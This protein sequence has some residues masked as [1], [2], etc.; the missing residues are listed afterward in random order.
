MKIF[1]FSLLTLLLLSGCKSLINQDFVY[2]EN[3]S[4]VDVRA[5]IDFLK[6]T[7]VKYHYD[8]N[9]ENRKAHIFSDLDQIG[10]INSSISLDSF[11]NRIAA[12]INSVDDGHSRIIHQSDINR[13]SNNFGINRI[14]N[15]VH[16]LRISNFLETHKLKEVLVNFKSSFEIKPTEKVLIDIRS[17]PGGSIENVKYFLSYFLPSKTELY[18]RLDIKSSNKLYNIISYFEEKKYNIKLAKTTG[19]KNLNGSPEIYLLINNEIASGSMLSSYHLQQNGA[20]IIGHPPNGLFNTF[21]NARGHKLPNSKIVYTTAT[22]RIFLSKQTPARME[23]M[24]Q[25]DYL[26]SEKMDINQII[27]FIRDR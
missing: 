15:S 11:E 1:Y 2:H 10:N 25:S 27:D 17:N 20:Y 23:D 4:P 16:Y 5:D 13:K 26:P 12:I 21:G 22:A 9:W 8:I 19:V 6:N 7:L 24:L 14:S 18:D 3:I